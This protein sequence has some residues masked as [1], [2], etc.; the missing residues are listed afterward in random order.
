[1]ASSTKWLYLHG[2]VCTSDMRRAEAGLHSS[3]LRLLQD[4]AISSTNFT[5]ASGPICKSYKFPLAITANATDADWQ[6]G[7]RLVNFERRLSEAGGR[8]SCFVCANTFLF[9]TILSL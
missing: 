7:F 4:V 3:N 8:M 9:T 6:R 2:V 5:G 1:M